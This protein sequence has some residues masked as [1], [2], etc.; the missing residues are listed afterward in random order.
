MACRRPPAVVLVGLV[1]LA[2]LALLVYRRAAFRRNA[3]DFHRRYDHTD[4]AQVDI[5]WAH[6]RSSDETPDPT[7]IDPED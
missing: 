6:E 1:A 3:D 5:E 4:L 2:G 7:R